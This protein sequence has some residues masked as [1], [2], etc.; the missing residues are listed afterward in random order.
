VTEIGEPV[1]VSV[2]T[3]ET[4]SPEKPEPPTIE[5]KWSKSEIL[6]VHN[7]GWPP[8]TPPT[9]TIPEDAKVALEAK[10]KNVP[11]GTKA[12]LIVHNCTTLRT[13]AVFRGMEV[14]GGEVVDPATGKA[15][16]WFFEAKNF[17]WVPWD[18]PF[19]FFRAMVSFHGLTAETPSD[20]KGSESSTLRV[21]Y[22]HGIISDWTADQPWT[23]SNNQVHSG[24]TTQAEMNEIAG[25]LEGNPHHKAV[26]FANRLQNVPVPHLG[27]VL[28]NTYVAHFASHGDFQH[29][30]SMIYLGATPFARS[31]IARASA[32][33]STPVYLVY[34]NCCLAAKEHSL[35]R[36]F[37]AR[38]T[39][40]FLGFRVSIPDG[41]AR[42][43]ARR[44]YRQWGGTYSMSPYK[45]PDVFYAVAPAFWG[46]MRPTLLGPRG[47]DIGFL[48]SL[49]DKVS[50][51]VSDIKSI[52]K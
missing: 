37:L 20:A 24:L 26:R 45:I 51:L 23:D 33:P 17:P 52:F 35:G 50:G 11:D 9:D 21:T 40:H 4:K 12:I 47:G 22:W 30:R 13:V 5:V 6:P 38:G 18:S 34:A 46:T 39:R 7:N 49:K 28:R 8:A 31:E 1:A 41:D 43:M 44:F 14:K 10:V 3:P 16:E 25:I 42:S 29:G 19:Y 2:P 48:D 32:V 36:A 27:S 15:P